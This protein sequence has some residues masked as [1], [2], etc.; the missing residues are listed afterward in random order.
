MQQMAREY[1][2]SM[3]GKTLPELNVLMIGSENEALVEEKNALNEF[4]QYRHR[5]YAEQVNSF[6]VVMKT[7]R[8]PAW[9]FRRLSD[10]L[11][12]YPTLSSSR[13]RGLFDMY[14]LSAKI[15]EEQNIDIIVTGDPFGSA[16]VGY[17]LKMKYK[18]PLCIQMFGDY[19]FNVQW[20]NEGLK[21]RCT[22]FVARWL[23]RKA[24]TVRVMSPTIKDLLVSR[25]MV[26]SDRIFVSPI[27]IQENKFGHSGGKEEEKRRE[28]LKGGATHILLT[29][30]RLAAQKDILTLLRAAQIVVKKI[31]H[32]LFVIVG[33]GDQRQ[34]LNDFVRT[35]NLEKNVVFTGNV[36]YGEV[37]S[38]FQACDLFVLS[39]AYEDT[40]RVLMEAA[41]SNK[42]I[43][44]TDT[45]GTR[46]I[47]KEGVNGFV[48]AVRD[49]EALARKIIYLLEHDDIRRTYASRS[50]GIVKG[51]FNENVLVEKLA[52]MWL[53]TANVNCPTF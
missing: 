18:R 52:G 37:P 34:V 22:A 3:S 48:V 26:R 10:K 6:H 33:D 15:I 5:Q 40:P 20:Q 45:T 46:D 17:L 42:A 35:N 24:D 9:S 23:F 13:L 25:G 51:A 31:P 12:T 21:K 1:Y 14:K 29:V 50:A 16:L 43:V 47:V 7:L 11:F 53:K 30:G 41:L 27:F 49:F 4:V 32:S 2:S 8:N 19:A 39:S 36:P 44:A 38:Y 28:L